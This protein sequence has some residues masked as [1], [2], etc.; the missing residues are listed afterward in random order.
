MGTV[1][2]DQQQ[3]ELTMYDAV[4]TFVTKD[5]S[6][7]Y[8]NVHHEPVI[9]K[10]YRLEFESEVHFRNWLLMA[11]TFGAV[12]TPTQLVVSDSGSFDL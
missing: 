11:S 6:H 9:T 7:T 5:T 2:M 10:V 3:G 1:D 12:D 8:P 4:I